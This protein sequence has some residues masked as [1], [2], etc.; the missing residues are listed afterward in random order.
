MDKLLNIILTISFLSILSCGKIDKNPPKKEPVISNPSQV[1]SNITDTS[2]QKKKDNST[3]NKTQ[4][5]TN[6]SNTNQSNT[7]QSNTNQS[8]TDQSN[9]DQSQETDENRGNV[10]DQKKPKVN[11]DRNKT[12]KQSKPKHSKNNSRSSN[13]KKTPIEKKRKISTYN[14]KTETEN[15]KKELIRK[16]KLEKKYENARK[17]ISKSLNIKKIQKKLET[18]KT[19]SFF[20]GLNL[21]LFKED[22][23]LIS[24]ESKELINKMKGH[25][26]N[27]M[28]DNTPHTFIDSLA[29]TRLLNLSF[30]WNNNLKKDDLDNKR[31]GDNIKNVLTNFAV[32]NHG[33]TE[34]SK[35]I[36][37]ILDSALIKINN[38]LEVL[39]MTENGDGITESLKYYLDINSNEKDR[40]YGKQILGLFL[41]KWGVLVLDVIFTISI[42]NTYKLD[43][44]YEDELKELKNILSKLLNSNIIKTYMKGKKDKIE[45]GETLFAIEVYKY[46]TRI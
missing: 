19:S 38:K 1:A 41:Q 28:L 18:E 24:K 22:N 30:T 36:I 16:Q 2:K 33:D 4:S 32:D 5:N 39:E 42:I 11:S 21:F 12:T 44:S 31:R 20:S 37:S 13:K 8:N 46:L 43:I 3:K 25:V 10:G 15:N 29:I 26:R 45:F 6:Q 34:N 27:K 17:K 40:I 23:H 9:T 7:N 35:K 14:S